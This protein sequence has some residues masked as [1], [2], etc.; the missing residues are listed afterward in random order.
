MTAS[1]S[2][3]GEQTLDV[4]G[5]AWFDH[6]WG[7][8]IAW[9]V[10]AGTGSRSTSTT[11]RTS[12]CRSCV[13]RTGATRWCTARSSTPMGRAGTSRPTRSRSRSRRIGRAADRRDVP[14]RLA[15][16]RSGRGP[17]DRARTDRRRPGARHARD[18]RRHLLGGLA[19]R[20]RNPSRRDARWRGYI[21]LTG[22]AGGWRDADRDHGPAESLRADPGNTAA[23]RLEL[24][25]RGDYAV[26]AMLSLA[27]H[28]GIG[29]LSV[30]RISAAMDIPERFL[31]RDDRPRPVR[32]RRGASRADRRLPA[33]SPGGVD[34][35]A[36]GDPG[37]R[38]RRRQRTCVLRGGPCGRDGT[39]AVHGV[40]SDARTAMLDRLSTARLA[41]LKLAE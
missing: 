5:S 7:D 13:T 17:R 26:R 2:L 30:A 6:Q 28:D 41:D 27:A 15:G 22:Y 25:R 8:F 24:T 9:A 34:L 10:V 37:G 14:G 35:A 23:M 19:G 31:P 32:A 11:A 12:R 29:W 36:R 3:V 16:H 21:E 1:G 33:R 40:F 39:C 20:P 38:T 4:E 18:D